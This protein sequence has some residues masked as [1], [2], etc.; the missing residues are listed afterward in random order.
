MDSQRF[1]RMDLHFPI[2]CQFSGFF[3]DPVFY[4]GQYALSRRRGSHAGAFIDSGFLVG[5]G[6]L[7][8]RPALRRLWIALVIVLVAYSIGVSLLLAVTGNE[9]RFENLNP[10]LFKQLEHWLTP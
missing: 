5:S 10:V 7:A 2:G 6:L 1:E 9:A 4:H 8:A 3:A